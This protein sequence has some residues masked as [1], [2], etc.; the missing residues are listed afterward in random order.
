MVA[1][2]NYVLGIKKDGAR[3]TND[4]HDAQAPKDPPDSPDGGLLRHASSLVVS[5]YLVAALGWAGTVL[6]VRELSI[7][8]WGRFSFVFSALAL[9]SIVTDLQ[10]G[11]VAIK[12]L[13]G[14]ETDPARFGGAYV[15]LRF[16]LGIAG[17]G[18]IV[19][20]VALMGYPAE[21]VRATAVAGLV[22]VLATP[23]NALHAVFFA[24]LR[25]ATVA[26]AQVLGQTAQFALTA[27]IAA[28][29]RGSVVIFVIPAIVFEVV[30]L[31]WKLG[32]V[33]RVQRLRYTVDLT[34]WRGLLREA[35][36]L[37]IGGAL[38]AL[39]FRIDSVLLSRLDT[40]TA[41]GIYGIGYKFVEVVRYAGQAITIPLLTML[42]RS[43]SHDVDATRSVFQRGLTIVVI[44]GA[45][46]A[47]EFAVFAEEA[48][49]LLYGARYV[50]GAD[51]ARLVVGAQCL[52]I[53]GLVATTGLVAAGRNVQYAVVAAAGLV[54]NVAL[55]LWL[56]PSRSYEGAAI[57]TLVTE[58]VVVVCL[59][60]RLRL[61][62]RLRPFPL[63]GPAAA[64][65]SAAIAGGVAALA[66]TALPWPLASAFS[67]V[68]YVA[69][70]HV[71][72][73]AGPGGLRS[74][75]AASPSR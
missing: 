57:A 1:V 60:G 21:V 51:A 6:I 38:M 16:F 35:A 65:A 19:A 12:G 46:L 75:V 17:Y 11:R 61:V 22:V 66:D 59:F 42:V 71:S 33:G 24:N 18:I 73:A 2:P 23:S 3:L 56:I 62:S 14:E 63:R 72:G 52:G 55:N 40:F 26:V 67:V 69:L 29:G 36:P 37:A 74:L 5:R 15:A 44:V 49:E 31:A 13:V 54:V 58:V 34:I 10:L 39:Y 32:W 9:L 4:V 68:A 30:A 47:A 25:S 27:A 41:V 20:F 8:E 50:P 45:I 53:V 70:V 28:S 43:W 7:D 64:V 48:I